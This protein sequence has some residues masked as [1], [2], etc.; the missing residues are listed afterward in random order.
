LLHDLYPEVIGGRF[1]DYLPV[2]EMATGR[3][4]LPSHRG[5]PEKNTRQAGALHIPE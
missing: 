1:N 5:L 3:F 4:D 2:F